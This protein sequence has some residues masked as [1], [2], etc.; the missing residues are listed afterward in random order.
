MFGGAKNAAVD[1]TV[2][3]AVEARPAT[4]WRR[5]GVFAAFGLAYVGGAQWFLFSRW[6][7]RAFPG[8]LEGRLAPA[9]RV[10]A[11]DQLVHMPFCYL[12]AFYGI[13]EVG[14]R[15]GPPADALART[16]A[17]WRADVWRD[18]L[19]QWAMFVPLQTA[20]M[21]LVPPPFRVPLLTAGGAVYVG[22]L[23]YFQGRA[24][25][26]APRDR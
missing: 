5:T 10:V 3:H 22:I 13:R 26:A 6:L 18:T 14:L 2:Q 20:N 7:P 23:S 16:R 21:T 24:D 12:P 9:L 19:A 15:G 25:P 11:F 17:A 8:L 4:D 1:L